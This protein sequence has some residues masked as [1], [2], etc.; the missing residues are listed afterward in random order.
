MYLKP[1]YLSVLQMFT[2]ILFIALFV[3][4]LEKRTTTNGFNVVLSMMAKA[5]LFFKNSGDI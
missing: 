3:G 5:F 1:L 4:G 2:Y